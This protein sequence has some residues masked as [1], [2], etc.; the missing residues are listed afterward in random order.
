M[1]TLC[2][3]FISLAF[4][5]CSFGGVETGGL[6]GEWQWTGPKPESGPLGP[7]VETYVFRADGTCESV[8]SCAGAFAPIRRNSTFTITGHTITFFSAD[9]ATA[10]APFAFDQGFLF[11]PAS[12]AHRFEK[13]K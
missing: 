12:P 6:V 9:G 10:T 7:L 4:S 13:Q 8:L 1:K 2:L 5:V 11:F 3:I